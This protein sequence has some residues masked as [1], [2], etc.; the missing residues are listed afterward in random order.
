[1]VLLEIGGILMKKISGIWILLIVFSLLLPRG[2]FA[3]RQ[4]DIDSIQE[5]LN[6]ISEEEKQ[7][8]ETLFSQVQEIQEL[9]R[10]SDALGI[11]INIIQGE[12]ENLEVGIERA[13][14]GY[15][16]NLLGLEKVLKSYQRM[17]AASYIDIVLES[18]SIASLIRRINILRDLSRNSKNLLE[19][20]QEDKNKL[21]EEK[22]NLSLALN[23]LEDKQSEIESNLE[24]LRKL[25]AEKEDY[26][27]S[28]E[29]DRDLYEERLDYISIIMDELQY[30]LNEFTLEF[31]K[32]IKSGGFPRNAVEESITLKGVRGVIRE[33]TFNNIIASHDNLPNME[34]AFKDGEI[35]M[36]VPDKKLYL[37]GNFVIED[38]TIL[39]FQP[40]RGSFLEMPLEK[41]TMDELF[42]QGNFLLNLKP[43][44]GNVKIKTV[45]VKDKYIELIVN[46]F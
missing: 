22:L 45:Q 5:K 42:K 9:E 18:D 21:S 7:I 4:K 3:E 6:S 10:N 31:D 14:L 30:I 38:N 20:I 17:G 19:E 37:S 2:V 34:F 35:S 32:V 16:R 28:L 43:L 44:I 8:L 24:E 23:R 36:K 27:D 1:M 13:E 25:V 29:G 12:I 39:K 26:L 15:E 46:I 40:E 41:A 11:E 33:K